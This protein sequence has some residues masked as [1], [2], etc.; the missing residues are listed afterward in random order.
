MAKCRGES[1]ETWRSQIYNCSRAVTSDCNFGRPG[2]RSWR[3]D[4]TPLGANGR[5]E[6]V[7]HTVHF[8][9]KSA[10]EKACTHWMTTRRPS[11]S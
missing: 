8:K 10:P 3:V 6:V 4:R 2:S 7:H 1:G 5:G 9:I 11:Q